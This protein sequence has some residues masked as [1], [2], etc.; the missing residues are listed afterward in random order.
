MA[1][2]REK[3]FQR[4]PA[5]EEL[6]QEI[7][8]LLHPVEERVIG[9]YDQPRYPIV[10]VV[11]VPRAGS[12]LMMQ[13]LA[14]TG[15]FAYPTNLLS[16]FYGAPYVGARIQRL[17]TDPLF[18]YGNELTEFD[19]E[20]KFTSTLGK[21]QGVLAPNEFWYFWR[22]FFPNTMPEKLSDE[23]LRGADGEGFVRELAALEAAFDKPFALKGLIL[24]LNIP[25]L[26][27]LFARALFLHVRRHPFY[28]AQSL[29]EARV[30]YYGRRDAWYSIKPPEY[31]HFSDADPFTQVAAQVHFTSQA[32]V[33]GL[34]SIDDSRSLTVEYED[35]CADPPAT[36]EAIL[37]KCGAQGYHVGWKYRGPDRFQSTNQVRLPPEDCRALAHACQRFNGKEVTP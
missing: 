26:S 25:F 13:W 4:N 12:T 9:A 35:F 21:T 19:Q 11:G 3:R 10:F 7:N 33:E 32:L 14:N 30:K 20:V 16:R 36:F 18:A 37:G 34:A 2:Q 27:G 5:L 1:P 29:L 31:P 24:E 17:L 6:L 23:Q 28:N 15:Y 8:D 22:R